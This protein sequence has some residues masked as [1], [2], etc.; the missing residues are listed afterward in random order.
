MPF[1]MMRFKEKIFRVVFRTASN[2]YDG[3]HFKYRRNLNVMV[4]V[5]KRVNIL[6]NTPPFKDV[7]I[8]KVERG[9]R[10]KWS[11]CLYLKLNEKCSL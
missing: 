9:K 1:V 8:F 7:R 5:S 2:S 10:E 4:S 6:Q 11:G 3:S